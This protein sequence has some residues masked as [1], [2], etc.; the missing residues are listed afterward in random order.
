M[1]K[2]LLAIA[3]LAFVG[4]VA[5][6]GPNAGGTIFLHN[7]NLT[8]TTQPSCCGLGT[9]PDSCLGAVTQID[10][11]SPDN[12]QV[13]KV[14]AAFPKGSSPRLLGLT[15]G[16]SYDDQYGDGNGTVVRGYGVC[17]DFELAMNGWPANDT[18][19]SVL[20][21]VAQTGLMTEIYWFAG[22]NY[23][24]V[25]TLFSLI[26]H[27][28]QGGYFVD[29]EKP[30]ILDP[31]AGYGTLGFNE[32][33]QTACPGFVGTGACCFPDGSCQL[34]TPTDCQNAGG[35][36]V[37]GACDPNPCKAVT[38]ACCIN[39]VCTITTQAGCQGQWMGPNTLCSPNPCVVVPVEV[40]S[41]GQIKNQYR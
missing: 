40:K 20:W 25:P 2:F 21:N 11:S 9:P 16:V 14:Y 29:D 35:S 34:L 37:G 19:D 22:Y 6:A 31:I 4:T 18:G 24:G 3:A 39:Q 8:Y 41:W 27:P 10:N 33:G 17:A 7:A 15:F 32:P 36:F 5:L 1:K 12:L 28:E 26:A 30:G 23:Y 38:G 13:W